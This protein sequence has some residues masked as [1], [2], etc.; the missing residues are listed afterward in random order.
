MY[1]KHETK[2][3]MLVNRQELC[4]EFIAMTLFPASKHIYIDNIWSVQINVQKSFF[5]YLGAEFMFTPLKE[6]KSSSLRL[7]FSS[8]QS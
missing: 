1:G 5:S 8:R 7:D 2:E 3:T 4:G 6:A